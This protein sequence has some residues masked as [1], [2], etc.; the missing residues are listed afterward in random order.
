MSSMLP[1]SIYLTQSY[2]GCCRTRDTRSVS[3]DAVQQ[4]RRVL[5]AVQLFRQFSQGLITAS[6][7]NDPFQCLL[8]SDACTNMADLVLP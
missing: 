3:A 1:S 4:Y 7:L 8:K 5:E 2:K 6:V